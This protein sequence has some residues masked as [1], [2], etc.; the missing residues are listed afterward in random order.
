MMPRKV[1]VK[2]QGMWLTLGPF[3]RPCSL[4][5]AGPPARWDQGSQA[6]N[7][8]YTEQPGNA[9]VIPAVLPKAGYKP[10]AGWSL[11]LPGY[12]TLDNI[13]NVFLRVWTK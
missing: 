5:W 9:G 2:N 8:D 12:Q 6:V 3:Q 10:V 7:S 11:N 1:L 4:L 13:S